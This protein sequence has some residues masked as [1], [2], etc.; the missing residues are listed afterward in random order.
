MDFA[1][2]WDF[3][4]MSQVLFTEGDSCYCK[5]AVR[6]DRKFIRQLKSPAVC[7]VAE[8]K[9]ADFRIAYYHATPTIPAIE[10]HGKSSTLVCSSEFSISL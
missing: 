7:Y 3:A 1:E 2:F 9:L 10:R 4:A 5:K 8:A 6:E